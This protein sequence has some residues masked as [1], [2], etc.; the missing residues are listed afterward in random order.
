MRKV[1]GPG[2]WKKNVKK[3]WCI[4]TKNIWQIS[5]YFGSKWTNSVKKWTFGA[6]NLLRFKK[7]NVPL[8]HTLLLTF[9][10]TLVGWYVYL[11]C[12]NWQ[13]IPCERKCYYQLW[14]DLS[15]IF[16]R[17]DKRI[18]YFN[19]KLNFTDIIIIL[20]G[21]FWTLNLFDFSVCIQSLNHVWQFWRH[22][23]LKLIK[24]REK[25]NI[26]IRSRGWYCMPLKYYAN[27]PLNGNTFILTQITSHFYFLSYISGQYYN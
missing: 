9:L 6:F 14:H 7:K 27:Y 11:L 5:L 25:N 26:P 20:G 21:H 19:F 12:I 16:F 24:I 4:L 13:F 17:H 10:C 3:K 23:F 1:W 2:K 15:F 8:T 18:E 22:H